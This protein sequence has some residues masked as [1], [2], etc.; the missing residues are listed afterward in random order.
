MNFSILKDS[1]SLEDVCKS[2]GVK[3]KRSGERLSTLCPFHTEKTPSFYVYPD[4]HF[5]CFG[6]GEHGTILDFTAKMENC[7]IH[8]A[9]E[10]LR[11]AFAPWI[12]DDGNFQAA[13][14]TRRRNARLLAE[15]RESLTAMA[16]EA[17]ILLRKDGQDGKAQ[18]IENALADSEAFENEDFYTLLRTCGLYDTADKVLKQFHPEYF[19]EEKPRGRGRPAKEAITIPLL[20]KWLVDNGITVRR[21]I[22]TKAVKTTGIDEADASPELI[23]SQTSIIIHDRVKAEYSCSANTIRDLLGVIAGKNEYNPILDLLKESAPWDGVDRLPEVYAALNLPEDDTLS[24]LLLKKWFIQCI[25]LQHNTKAEAFGGEGCLILQGPQFI[26][27]TSFARKMALHTLLPGLFKEGMELKS[28]KDSIMQATSAWIV[29]LGEISGTMN[30]TDMNFL[31]A[32]LTQSLDEYRV[33]Y[34]TTSAQY[35]RRTSYIGTVNDEQFLCDPTGSRRWWVIPVS[36]ISLDAVDA[37][38]KLQFWKQ[39]EFYATENLQSFRL[40]KEE[41]AA[42]NRR[43]TAFEKSAAAVEEIRDIFAN[44][45]SFPHEYKW[46]W[47]DLSKYKTYWSVLSSYSINAIGLAMKTVKKEYDIQQKGSVTAVEAKESGLGEGT[48][49]GRFWLLPFPVQA[50]I[51]SSPGELRKDS[52]EPYAPQVS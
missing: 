1:I 38:D 34:G 5:H 11:Q 22:V 40:T 24:R 27:K 52:G 21:N 46:M 43:N 42:L 18:T 17:V 13:A 33:P 2:Y 48:K 45:T 10:K 20:E 16:K 30:R 35:A 14:E 28:E 39:I 37:L 19:E 7:G 41:A 47:T 15:E 50:H 44:A 9:A 36:D 12:V 25:S 4:G 32:F 31:K 51:R 23:E 6:C 3:F 49:R 8:E 29:E 26:G